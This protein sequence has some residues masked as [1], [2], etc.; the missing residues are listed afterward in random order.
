MPAMS[1]IK[2]DPSIEQM[3][4]TYLA[5]THPTADEAVREII[6]RGIVDAATGVERSDSPL[7]TGEMPALQF[8]KH[9]EPKEPDMH[10][11]IQ[12]HFG[13]HP[14]STADDMDQAL[15]GTN[16][17]EHPRA[18][19]RLKTGEI[20]QTKVEG[21][22]AQFDLLKK[23]L[24]ELYGFL[25]KKVSG[26]LDQTEVAIASILGGINHLLDFVLPDILN[27]LG[28]Q[29]LLLYSTHNDTEGWMTST[30][31]TQ[32]KYGSNTASVLFKR[33]DTRGNAYILS[34]KGTATFLGA[35]NRV[36]IADQT[37]GGETGYRMIY[38]SSITDPATKPKPHT[39]LNVDRT[40]GQMHLEARDVFAL[41]SILVK[42]ADGLNTAYINSFLTDEEEE[43]EDEAGMQSGA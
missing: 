33:H 19:R 21:R 3:V 7:E 13:S 15:E 16:V 28:T 29:D 42:L 24:T 17:R 23:T 31:P 18:R 38:G 32:I 10:R 14:L 30:A 41:G 25:T 9:T 43:E 1:E 27:D 35:F 8:P 4:Q 2:P 36:C 39:R 26:S 20:V 37:T 6:R 5:D 12:G 11:I 34:L 22:K 40:R